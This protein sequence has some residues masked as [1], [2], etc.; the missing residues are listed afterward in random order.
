MAMRAWDFP[1]SQD[2]TGY[3][4]INSSTGISRGYLNQVTEYLLSYLNCFALFSPRFLMEDLIYTNVLWT[5]SGY[6]LEL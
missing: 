4:E 3:K 1:Q 5:V 6:F 2:I